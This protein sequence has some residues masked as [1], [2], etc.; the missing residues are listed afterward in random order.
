METF[1]QLVSYFA[2]GVICFLVIDYHSKIAVEA[3]KNHTQ[4]VSS[5][6]KRLSDSLDKSMD[7]YRGSLKGFY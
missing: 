7:I 5:G 1:R 4:I 6:M 2:F 3:I